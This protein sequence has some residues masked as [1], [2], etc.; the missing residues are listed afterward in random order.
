MELPG[1]TVSVVDSAG[2]GLGTGQVRLARTGDGTEAPATLVVPLPAL[3]LRPAVVP[4][5]RMTVL[6]SVWVLVRPSLLALRSDQSAL[7]EGLQ[8]LEDLL[9]R[10]AFSLNKVDILV[11]DEAERMLD[12][13]FKPAI[14]RIVKMCPDDRQ[15]L[16]FSAT[17]DG[18]AGRL[19]ADFTVDPVRRITAA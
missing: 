13:G 6:R 18:E 19:A 2:H 15:T 8:R 12:M 3:A 16:F 17:L 7:W 5:L 9:N 14:D 11:L 4:T 1:T 10:R